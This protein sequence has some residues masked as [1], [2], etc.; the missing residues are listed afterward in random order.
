MITTAPHKDSL[1]RL[2]VETTNEI[3]T[4]PRRC[5][6]VYGFV[7]QECPLPIRNGWFEFVANGPGQLLVDDED[8]ISEVVDMGDNFVCIREPSDVDAAGCRLKFYTDAS[9]TQE[10]ESVIIEVYGLNAAGDEIRTSVG[11]TRRSGEQVTLTAAAGNVTTAQS[12]ATLTQV[13]KPNTNGVVTV[14][15][16]D[17]DDS[18]ETLI[19]R[20]EPSEYLP[21]YR[22]YK[23]PKAPDN[24][25]T[26]SPLVLAKR[27]FVAAVQMNDPLDIDNFNALSNAIDAVV[28]R[29][30][31]DTARYM[32]SL[33]EARRLLTLQNTSAR[34]AAQMPQMIITSDIQHKTYHGY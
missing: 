27:R 11:T 3:M 26:Y 8:L 18:S 31:S 16:I 12:F 34:P 19:A 7:R 17:P 2:F 4:L 32:F 10:V 25:D 33:G 1:Q 15:A 22:R 13:V 5:A 6:S 21:Q 14:Y 20:Y 28:Y 9:S 24:S 30:R 29:D 23:V